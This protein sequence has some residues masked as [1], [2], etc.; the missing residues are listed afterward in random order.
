MADSL[1]A[2]NSLT[3]SKIAL[4]GLSQR[5]QAISRNLANVDTPGYQSQTVDFKKAIA[6]A[7]GTGSAITLATTSAG[8]MTGSKSAS[9]LLSVARPGG[10]ER[11]DQN[12]VDIDTELLDMSQ[13]AITYNAIS[14]EVSQ[15]LLLLKA[16]ATG[17]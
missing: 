10:T 2:D 16:I 1:F 14:Q 4:D 15:K 17:G 3:A 8:H 6:S 13:T 12:N 5:Q 9:S 11:A 7:M